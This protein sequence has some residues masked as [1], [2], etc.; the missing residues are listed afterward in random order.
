MEEYINIDGFDFKLSSTPFSAKGIEPKSTPFPAKEI[1][2]KSTPF[3]AKGIE[4]KST[5]FPAKEIE[6][7][8]TP[9]AGKVKIKPPGDFTCQVCKQSFKHNKGLKLHFSKKCGR[10]TFDCHVCGKKF[11]KKNKSIMSFEI[12]M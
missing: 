10:K 11:N 5:P 12:C 7:K 2:P 4:P 9:L 1:E 8:S 3:S 6:P